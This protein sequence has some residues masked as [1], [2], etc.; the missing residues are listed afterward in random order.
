MCFV[1]IWEQTAIIS[2]YSIN[3]LVFVTEGECVYCAV[4]TEPLNQTNTVSSLEGYVWKVTDYDAFMEIPWAVKS[5]TVLGRRPS[6][7]P[8][9]FKHSVVWDRS[10]TYVMRCWLLNHVT[11]LKHDFYVNDIKKSFRNTTGNKLRH[12]H[13]VLIVRAVIPAYSENY[14]RISGWFWADRVISQSLPGTRRTLCLLTRRSAYGLQ[15]FLIYQHDF[16]ERAKQ[17]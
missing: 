10:W 16:N 1:W 11:A 7:L 9:Y 3:W 13:Y 5:F 8:L 17:Q 2:L 4:R 6:P 14:R 12:S 15:K